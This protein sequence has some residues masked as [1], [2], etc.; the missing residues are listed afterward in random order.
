VVKAHF[1]FERN[2]PAAFVPADPDSVSAPCGI[3]TEQENEEPF[4]FV[5]AQLSGSR[6][7]FL[8]RGVEVRVDGGKEAMA[9]IVGFK[10]SPEFQERGGVGHALGGQINPGKASKCLTVV[11][12][13]FE[14]YTSSNKHQKS[15]NKSASP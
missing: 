11:E 10:Q 1:A 5:K 8:F 2:V 3:L 4:H 7:L 9:Q 15:Q 6:F 13:V 14:S 12:R